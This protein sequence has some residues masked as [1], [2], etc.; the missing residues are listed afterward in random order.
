MTMNLVLVLSDSDDDMNSALDKSKENLI[1]HIPTN[2]SSKNT[3]S[4]ETD[5]SSSNHS[6]KTP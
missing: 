6:S 1:D 4:H 3:K 5:L 2:K